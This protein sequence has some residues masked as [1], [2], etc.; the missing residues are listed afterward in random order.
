MIEPKRV[1]VVG[2]GQ[3]GAGYDLDAP[4][5]GGVYTH[6]RAASRHPAFTLSGG[7]DPAAAQRERF[8]AHYTA[9]GFPGI[10]EAM[11]ALRP[12]VV[13]IASP[14]DMHLQ[15]VREVLAAGQPDVILCEKPLALTAA[16]GEQLVK[17]CDEAD[18]GLFVNFIRRSEPGAV[19]VAR[20]I[21][22][23]TI[24]APLKGA[25]WYSKGL[26]NNGSHFINLLQYWL[27]DVRETAVL[28]KGRRWAGVDPEPDVRLVFERGTVVLQAAREEAFSF[29]GGEFVSP[30]GR[31]LYG[32]GGSSIAWQGVVRDDNFAGYSVLSPVVENIH[33]DMDRY[34][35]HVYEQLS[36]CIS[37]Q[38]H[39]LCSG[40]EALATLRVVSA[41]AGPY[42]IEF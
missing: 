4:V 30:S 25:F 13:A 23:G 21:A 3:I 20:R 9:P 41:I 28:D 16:E 36:R 26:Y 40:G 5:D 33:N 35:W 8:E 12:K 37:G 2:L 19:D 42:G 24:Q 39:E 11:Q 1:L 22:A 18:V 32:S 7:V 34:Q 10:A 17:S 31:L 15:H 38:A 6:A 29:Y 14:A 27:G